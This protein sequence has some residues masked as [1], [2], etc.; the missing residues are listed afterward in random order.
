MINLDMV[1]RL[2]NEKLNVGGIGTATEWK[3][4]VE[5]KN[6]LRDPAISKIKFQPSVIPVSNGKVGIAVQPFNLALNE[7]G[8]GPS[9][10]SSFYGK[11]IPVL[12]FFTGTHVDYHKPSDTAEKINYE[13]LARITN[14][15]AD[16]VYTIDRD[17][18]RP[19]YTTAKSSGIAGRSTGFSVSL[20]T[21]PSYADST[22][23]LVLDGVRD[24][25]PAAKAGIKP[26][27]KVVKLAGKEVR[28]VMDYTY[29]LGELKAGEEYEVEL[30]RDGRHLTLKIVPA[31]AARR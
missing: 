30:I 3:A 6:G 4:L 27:D 16:I 13:G 14:Y 10:H 7:D 22:D 5:S 9:D 18:R 2:T 29:I 24:G 20:G 28:N 8:F 1:G 17:P 15:V 26:G 23:G 19:T 12:F 11:Q 31:P 25:S 21:V